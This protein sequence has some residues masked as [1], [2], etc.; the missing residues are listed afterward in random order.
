MVLADTGSHNLI[1][2]ARVGS[3]VEN[4]YVNIVISC[5]FP[6]LL[7]GKNIRYV[8]YFIYSAVYIVIDGC[9]VL[10]SPLGGNKNNPAG[11]P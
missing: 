2:P 4:T 11:R 8:T 6:V 10:S 1:K 5:I 7:G 3:K 9:P